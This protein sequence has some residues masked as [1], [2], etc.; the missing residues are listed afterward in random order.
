MNRVL[1][2]RS[3]KDKETDVVLYFLP[4]NEYTPYVTWVVRKDNPGS[5]FWGHY[6]QTREEAEEDFDKR[7]WNLDKS[8]NLMLAVRRL[9]GSFEDELEI[10]EKLLGNKE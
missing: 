7:S 6:F 9:G 8:V 5:T 2:E 10:E 1:L 3:S 4:D